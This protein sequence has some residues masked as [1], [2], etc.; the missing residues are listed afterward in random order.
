MYKI[1][2]KKLI[3]A[4]SML[5]LL[6]TLS[7]AKN[8]IDQVL[9]PQS[10][11]Y[12]SSEINFEP[13][14]SLGYL[15]GKANEYVY[16]PAENHTV[17]Q[18][19]WDIKSQT[20]LG[21]GVSLYYRDTLR[22][23]ADIWFSIAE[24]QA[25]MKDYDWMIKGLD[26]THQSIHPNT[27]V[28]K[29]SKFDINIDMK[30]TL[31]KTTNIYGLI[32]YIQDTFEWQASGGSAIYSSDSFRDLSFTI[33]NDKRVIT[34]QQTWS[35]PYVGIKIESQSNELN[36][37]AKLIYS[38]LVIGEALDTHHLRNMKGIDSFI[39]SSML[40]FNV[41]L[42]YNLTDTLNLQ[43][44]YFYQKYYTAVGDMELSGDEGTYKDLKD[45]AGAD[46]KTSMFSIGLNYRY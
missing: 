21:M 16:F 44:N 23:N 35:V 12:Q 6:F 11:G 26:W 40:G 2:N 41:G 43:V 19:I 5:T 8:T 36:L 18:L 46:L 38:P 17:S 10:I 32:G 14:V 31:D 13:R 3:I 9:T 27:D 4:F 7:E 37:N 24:G 29:A 28:A 33:P 39:G 22:L 34:Y 30:Y 25:H 45:Y 42:A 1:K 20:M 15:T